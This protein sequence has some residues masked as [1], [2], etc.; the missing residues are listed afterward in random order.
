VRTHNINCTCCECYPIHEGVI[1]VFV[2]V[3][4]F[5]RVYH[6]TYQAC[7]TFVRSFMNVTF[8]TSD[9]CHMV[10]T[11]ASRT[12]TLASK[13]SITR[14]CS[15]HMTDTCHMVGTVSGG[16]YMSLSRMCSLHMTGHAYLALAQLHVHQ[17][18]RV[19]ACAGVC[20]TGTILSANRRR[21]L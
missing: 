19:C 13:N 14:M 17:H 3:C 15:L 5:V 9:T 16:G 12:C 7:L 20:I 10:G 21:S 18:T 1:C 8:E 11:V 2:C 4:L 6:T